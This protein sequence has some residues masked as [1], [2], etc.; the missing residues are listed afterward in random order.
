MTRLNQDFEVVPDAAESWDVSD[1][2]LTWTFHIRKGLVW[3]DDTPLN[4][5]DFV[6]TFQRAANPATAYDAGFF[7]ELIAGIKNWTEVAAGNLP[8]DQLGVKALD[9]YTVQITTRSPRPFFLQTMKE[10]LASPKQMFDKYGEDWAS[11][12]KTMVFSGP[13]AVSEWVDKDHITLTPNTKYNGPIK[14][15]LSQYKYVYGLPENAFPAYLNNEI[16]LVVPLGVSE[17]KR[18]QSDPSLSSALHNWPHWRQFY[19]TFDTFNPPF[20]NLKVRQA[21]AQ[22]ID[23][24]TLCNTTLK[25]TAYPNRTI[26]MPGFPAYSADLQAVQKYDPATAKQLF[27]D[28]GFPSGQNFPSV[29]LWSRGGDTPPLAKPAGEFIQAQLKQNLGIDIGFREV[30]RKTFTDAINAHTHNFFIVPYEYDY[31]DP[32]DLLDLF[33]PGSRHAW[34]ND[35]YTQLVTQADGMF[36]D[37]EQRIAVYQQAE[38][39]LVQDVGCAFLFGQ[40]DNALWRPNLR[41]AAVSKNKAGLTTWTAEIADAAFELYVAKG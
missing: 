29:E 3:T 10:G 38:K 25:D 27:A 7:F 12:Q 4:A 39:I 40:T 2:H 22:A 6:W 32:S 13:F 14:P 18:A 17:L 36:G 15:G 21:I 19:I 20:D 26:L 37:P 9:D 41:G 34:K 1:D 24:E 31:V 11:D 30:E 35:Q 28:A 33:L 16:D 8:V 5:H 23:V